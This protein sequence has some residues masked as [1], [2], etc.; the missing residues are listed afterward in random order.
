M[1]QPEFGEKVD[2]IRHAQPARITP[3]T[4]CTATRIQPLTGHYLLPFR[5]GS[6]VPVTE[7]QG[8][9]PPVPPRAPNKRQLAIATLVL[10]ADAHALS[11]T[12]G[13]Q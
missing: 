8:P 12:R 7:G 5:T 10:P 2:T 9:L 3:R 13:R 1:P 4:T 11:V 6:S